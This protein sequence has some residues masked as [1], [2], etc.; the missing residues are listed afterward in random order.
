MNNKR[1]GIEVL[2]W[3]GMKDEFLS[4]LKDI[5][6]ENP[7]FINFENQYGENA[8]HIAAKMDNV[9]IVKWLIENTNID[10]NKTIDKGNALSIAVEHNSIKTAN[11]LI[12]ETNIDYKVTTKEG[13]N[14]FHL[15]MQH[16]NESLIEQ[17][18]TKYPQGINCLDNKNE[19]CLFDFILYFSKHKKYYLFDILQESIDPDIFKVINLK[20]Q[21]L[22][23]FTLSII[24]DSHTKIEK[25]LKEELLFSLISQLKFYL[26]KEIE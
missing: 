7:H 14:I 9:K 23:D 15:L 11:Y 3:A 5:L 18:L 4:N 19:H 13:K 21:N 25:M 1:Y 26:E 10:F 16:G 2:H 20:K 17:L 12:N 8:I 22:L 6:I 24:E